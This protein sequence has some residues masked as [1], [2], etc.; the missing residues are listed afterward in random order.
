MHNKSISR[1]T[2]SKIR[3][4][5]NSLKWL[6]T[7]YLNESSCAN[8]H[9]YYDKFINE[10]FNC[11]KEGFKYLVKNWN[12]LDPN[13]NLAFNK[14]IEA[15][16]MLCESGNIGDI[17]TC[18]N[19]ICESLVPK[20]RNGAQAMDY[21]KMKTRRF[22]TKLSTK[23]TSKIDNNKSAASDIAKDIQAKLQVKGSISSAPA[24]SQTKEEERVEA[25]IENAYIKIENS[26]FDQIQCDRILKNHKTLS[27]YIDIDSIFKESYDV[28]LALDEICDLITRFNSSVAVQYNTALENSWYAINKNGLSYNNKSLVNYITDY[29]LFRESFKEEDLQ[30]I[31]N[32]LKENKIID[33]TEA[34]ESYNTVNGLEELDDLYTLDQY[35]LGTLFESDINIL[36]EGLNKAQQLINNFKRDTKKT[37]EKLKTFITKFFVLSKNNI[38]DGTP[39]V[40]N[41]IRQ[42][43]VLSTLAIHPIVF[44][45]TLIVD[46]CIKMKLRRKE[47]AKIR[48]DIKKEK[49]KVKKKIDSAKSESVKNRLEEYL[50]SLDSAYKKVDDYYRSL[51]TDDENYKRDEEEGYDDDEE[52]DFDFDFGSDDFNIESSIKNDIVDMIILAES[53]DLLIEKNITDDIIDCL[54]SYSI[55]EI[56]TVTNFAC[57]SNGLVNTEKLKEAMEEYKDSILS[58]SDNSSGYGSVLCDSIYKLN[59]VSE[60]N[61]TIEAAIILADTAKQVYELNSR[62]RS[63]VVHEMNI[64]NTL[65]LAT[66]KVKKTAVSLSDKEKAVSRTIDSSL[67]TLRDSTERALRNDNREAIIRGSMLPSA[68][69]IIKGAIISGAA[70]A[71]NPA[72]AVI[73]VLGAF[74][75]NKRLKGK[76]RQLILDDIE[77]ELK[78]CEKYIRAAEDNNDMK[79]LKQLYTI[80]KNLERQKQ[81]IKYNMKVKFNQNVPNTASDNDD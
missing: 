71:V 32:I 31:S 15:F 18:S 54:R 47:T 26:I 70:F 69:K 65:K 24:S 29:F 41:M 19:I 20:V 42:F 30:D 59:N 61:Y 34:F 22:K 5:D 40:L 33:F 55:G 75:A 64:S 14:I 78:M 48:D 12:G 16:D 2:M 6:E 37:P 38:V 23:I 58:K 45:T 56:V 51:H 53:I 43:V 72:I 3:N 50:K 1:V 52:F 57:I 60:F 44:C 9:S 49:D 79:A 7:G 68:S 67:N 28:E 10:K 66:D 11:N 25:A 35:M 13:S 81:R 27:K 21:I 36:E 73:G 17:T 74:A 8:I 77:I 80:Q 62:V 46:Y 39:S 63:G 4:R 76:E